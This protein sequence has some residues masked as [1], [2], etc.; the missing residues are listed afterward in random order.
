MAFQPFSSFLQA[1]VDAI[2]SGHW[3]NNER[4]NADITDDWNRMIDALGSLSDELQREVGH[5]TGLGDATM[6][7]H[8]AVLDRQKVIFEELHLPPLFLYR[9]QASLS[10]RKAVISNTKTRLRNS[11][12]LTAEGATARLEP[13]KDANGASIPDCPKTIA[14]IQSLQYH[15]AKWLLEAL[16]VECP[17][18]LEARRRA[19]MAEFTMAQCWCESTKQERTPHQSIV[20]S[21]LPSTTPRSKHVFMLALGNPPS[22]IDF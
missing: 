14:D 13:L 11:K 19:V 9:R 6:T 4:W 18:D 12:R 15:Q 8:Q 16:E 1:T 20:D 17:G 5:G 10:G 22:T 3:E 21:T 7:Q 2:H